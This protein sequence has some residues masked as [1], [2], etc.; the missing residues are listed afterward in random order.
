MDFNHES[1]KKVIVQFMGQQIGTIQ[2]SSGKYWSFNMSDSRYSVSVRSLREIANYIEVLESTK[3][4]I[5]L[6]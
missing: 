2:T 6:S 1:N 5:E 4:P 3:L